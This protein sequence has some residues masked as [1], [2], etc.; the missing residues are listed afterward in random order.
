[1]IDLTFVEKD[2]ESLEQRWNNTARSRREAKRQIEA[3]LRALKAH[4]NICR[5]EIILKD[6]II[7][8]HK[9]YNRNTTTAAW[10]QTATRTLILRSAPKMK[11]F[12]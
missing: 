1:M 12:R 6:G 9:V 8:I 3:H 2:A 10:I 4:P 5:V 7:E 11:G